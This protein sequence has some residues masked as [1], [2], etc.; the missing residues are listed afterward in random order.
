M[1][2]RAGLQICISC[3]NSHY[4]ILNSPKIPINSLYFLRYSSRYSSDMISNM[5][6]SMKK[7]ENPW[8]LA[9]IHEKWWILVYQE[10]SCQRIHIRVHNLWG[11]TSRYTMNHMFWIHEKNIWFRVYREVSRQRILTTE[12]RYEFIYMK[13]KITNSYMNSYMKIVFMNSYMNSH[14]NSNMNS[15]LNFEYEFI[16][17]FIYK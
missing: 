8:Y 5:I 16:Y 13:T 2:P 1:W 11:D 14:M 12:F 17:E 3:K 7:G 4:N 6:S 10:V 15:Y 9:W